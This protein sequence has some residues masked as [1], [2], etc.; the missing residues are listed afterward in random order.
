MNLERGAVKVAGAV[1]KAYCFDG[2]IF[3]HAGVRNGGVFYIWLYNTLVCNLL[4]ILASSNEF[5]DRIIKFTQYFKLQPNIVQLCHRKGKTRG[6]GWRKATC[7]MRIWKE[8]L[9]KWRV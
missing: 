4:D 6:T 7:P 1:S 3:L 9:S 5:C 8:G 2:G